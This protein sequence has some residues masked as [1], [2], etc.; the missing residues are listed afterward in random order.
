MKKLLP[1]VLVVA[2]IVIGGGAYLFMNQGKTTVPSGSG[3]PASKSAKSDTFMGTLKEA[4]ALGVGMKCTYKVEGNEYEGYVKGE[5][6]KGTIKT[7]EGKEGGVIMK[8]NCMWTWTEGE[9]QGVKFCYDETDVETEETDVWEQPQG[10]VGPDITYSCVP[11]AVT[12]AQ[13]TPPA[14]VNFLDMESMM[15][16]FGVQ[17]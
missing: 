16:G 15:E 13:F 14:D 5:N 2:L 11:F 12:D 3:T 9:S 6:Y 10:T 17:E 4:V 7:A 8:D 1:I